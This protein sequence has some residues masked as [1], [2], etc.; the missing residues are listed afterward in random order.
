MTYTIEDA[1]KIFVSYNPVVCNTDCR[2]Y[3]YYDGGCYF[4][5]DFEEKHPDFLEYGLL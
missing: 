1:R 4:Q 2:Y 3:R 5:E